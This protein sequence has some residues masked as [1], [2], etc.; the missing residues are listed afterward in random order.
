MSY[1][2]H[3]NCLIKIVTFI[4]GFFLFT[5]KTDPYVVLSLGDQVIR[6]KKNSQTTVIGPPGKP[7]WNQVGFFFSNNLFLVLFFKL[8]DYIWSRIFICWFLILGRR[9]SMLK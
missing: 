9:N 4:H 6:S 8:A 1:I 2:M 5:A 3:K 7:I